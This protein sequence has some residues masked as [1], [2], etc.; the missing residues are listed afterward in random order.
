MSNLESPILN[1]KHSNIEEEII[2]KDEIIQLIEEHNLKTKEDAKLKAIFS[3]LEKQLGVGKVKRSSFF[4]V[5][6]KN[7]ELSRTSLKKKADFYFQSSGEKILEKLKKIKLLCIKMNEE[8]AVNDIEYIIDT[9]TNKDL[10][11]LDLSELNSEAKDTLKQYSQA[12]N[13]VQ[14]SSDLKKIAIGFSKKTILLQNTQENQ[15]EKKSSVKGL[16][17][18][19]SKAISEL[20]SLSLNSSDYD[21]NSNINLQSLQDLN[22]LFN[23]IEDFDFDIFELDKIAKKNSLYY[24][25]R[26]IFDSLYFF[27]DL[28]PENKFKRFITEI[29]NG[30][31]RNVQYHND[32][33]A[34]DVLQTTYVLMEKGSIYY[35][36]DLTE[37]DYIS[38]LLSAICHDFKHPGIGNSYLINSTHNIALS[39]N[40][41]LINIL[42]FRLFSIGELPYC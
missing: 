35:K 24:I 22:A 18:R 8:E 28:I 10:N 25:S 30:Y 6:S 7:K 40:G 38:I 11:D 3:E 9:L 19:N 16:N 31:S 21:K 26:E 17:V 27:E 13:K 2:T 14:R 37:L 41:K 32:L 34:A 23:K 12:E 29:T 1:P 33:H 42:T 39:F 15:L 5:I 4:G 36:C 20:S